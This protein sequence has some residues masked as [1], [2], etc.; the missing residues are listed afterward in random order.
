M[1]LTVTSPMIYIFSS[2]YFP[3]SYCSIPLLFCTAD[4]LEELSKTKVSNFF[5]IT[6]VSFTT[7]SLH[8][9]TNDLHAPKSTEQFSTPTSLKEHRV[10]QFLLFYTFSLLAL[11]TSKYGFSSIHSLVIY[12]QLNLFFLSHGSY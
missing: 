1:Q 9:D 4:L 11:R 3:I 6:R 8:N 5:P 2:S 12:S 7:T 10:H